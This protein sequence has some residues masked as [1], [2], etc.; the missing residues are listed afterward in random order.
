M[1]TSGT[2]IQSYPMNPGNPSN[3]E[4]SRDRDLYISGLLRQTKGSDLRLKQCDVDSI[5]EMLP[6]TV[7]D[8]CKR[9]IALMEFH[10][11]NDYK[12]TTYMVAWARDMQH[13]VPVYCIRHNGRDGKPASLFEIECRFSPTDIEE[14]IFEL[15]TEKEFIEWVQNLYQQHLQLRHPHLPS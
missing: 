4:R 3:N 13:P 6:Q 8:W 10:R 11:G 12:S 15:S 9:P 14:K 5:P 1:V 2:G 7:C